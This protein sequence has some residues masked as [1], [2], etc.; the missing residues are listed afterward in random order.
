MKTSSL[1]H[2][3][4]LLFLVFF[5]P[6]L[7]LAQADDTPWHVDAR[8]RMKIH[9]AKP[10]V[11]H[12]VDNRKLCLPCSVDR[13]AAYDAAGNQIAV[14][15][16]PDGGFQIA[17]VQK[18]TDAYLYFGPD[19][20]FP[21]KDEDRRINN[22]YLCFHDRGWDYWNQPNDWKN[23]IISDCRNDIENTEVTDEVRVQRQDHIVEVEKW[24]DSATADYLAIEMTNSSDKKTDVR[25]IRTYVDHR[26]N[27]DAFNR[28]YTFC[29][30]LL[31]REEGDYVFRVT[32]NANHALKIDNA[33]RLKRFGRRPSVTSDEVTVHLAP[34]LHDFV[35]A[36]HQ[37]DGNIRFS[38]EW[39]KPGENDFH[40]L[41]E[42]DFA[43]AM[44]PDF[45]ELA[46]KSGNRYPLCGQ[47]YSFRV[48]LE[49][50]KS[51]TLRHLVPLTP[52]SRGSF[53]ARTAPA[54]FDKDDDG[55]FLSSGVQSFKD[56][57]YDVFISNDG[58]PFAFT[59]NPPDGS[60]LKPFSFHMA[61]D[62]K[63]AFPVPANVSLK[64]W[65]PLFLYDD[66]KVSL[67]REIRTRLPIPAQACL[68]TEKRNSG[69]P[70]PTDPDRLVISREAMPIPLPAFDSSGMDTFRA[71]VILKSE[72]PLSGS[73]VPQGSD[74]CEFEY[75]LELPGLVFDRR[76]IVFRTVDRLR[77]SEFTIAPDGSFYDNE[78]KCRLVPVLKRLTLRELREWELP[79]SI[80]PT[81]SILVIGENEGSFKEDL[82]EELGMDSARFEFI[83][84][85]RSA[86]GFD[87]LESLPDIFRTLSDE[88]KGYDMLLV[89]PPNST[90][91]RS[92]APRDEA[93]AI[94]FILE[95]AIRCAHIPTIAVSTPI[96]PN[97]ANPLSDDD[98][99]IG[100]LRAFKRTYGIDFLEFGPDF[101]D[102]F[103]TPGAY[104]N[105][106]DQTGNVS[107]SDFPAA[108]SK[109]LATIFANAL[110]KTGNFIFP[111]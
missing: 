4:F 103:L 46:D 93:R 100:E 99:Y 34:D 30:N 38:I 24:S 12:F 55:L 104:R 50:N 61:P 63:R 23:R 7:A 3:F 52:E 92:L 86:S 64:L 19:Q 109:R 111:R 82:R 94:A 71:D 68:L 47:Q 39:K 72:Q 77:P 88:T 26:I 44:I 10:G 56:P 83:P 91:R 32:S 73:E 21:T 41:Y 6:V 53:L 22:D 28:V 13:M 5:V 84:W 36:Y 25:M 9:I 97:P 29:G 80:R 105:A 59:L 31:I 74:G 15:H 1:S 33:M 85:T 101:E 54:D 42:D 17:P 90:R 89:I 45:L 110:R 43:P 48:F 95:A 40:E 107:E 8:F 98:D 108:A 18:E 67:T 57:G 66:D 87:T 78:W 20:G 27:E 51:V 79:R 69:E 49:K 102:I 96:P 35:A 76:K 106:P 16:F 11:P 60:S 70:V 75:L 58:T 14:Y 37:P 81:H 65:A 2:A 62:S